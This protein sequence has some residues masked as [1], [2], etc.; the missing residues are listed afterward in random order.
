MNIKKLIKKSAAIATLLTVTTA[1][2]AAWTPDS[3]YIQEQYTDGKQYR[4]SLAAAEPLSWSVFSVQLFEFNTKGGYDVGYNYIFSYNFGEG[5]DVESDG[6]TNPSLMTR[7]DLDISAAAWLK[8]VDP[9]F[10]MSFLKNE[11]FE[12]GIIEFFSGTNIN[13]DE[14]INLGPI[15][16][17]LPFKHDVGNLADMVVFETGIYDDDYSKTTYFDLARVAKLS[18]VSGKIGVARGLNGG[19]GFGF[20]AIDYYNNSTLIGRQEHLAYGVDVSNLAG[21]DISI[22]RRDYVFSVEPTITA[23]VAIMADISMLGWNVAVYYPDPEE[24]DPALISGTASINVELPVSVSTTTP[25]VYSVPSQAEPE[26]ISQELYPVQVTLASSKGSVNFSSAGGDCSGIHCAININVGEDVTLT[27]QALSGYDHIWSGDCKQLNQRCVVSSTN[28]TSQ[29]VSLTYI[30]RVAPVITLPNDITVTAPAYNSSMSVSL[31]NASAIDDIDGSVAVLPSTTGPFGVGEH[32]ITWQ[33]IDSS[34]NRATAIQRVTVNSPANAAVFLRE[35]VLDGTKFDGGEQFQKTWTMVNV[36]ANTWNSS[37][38]LKH[39]TG[40]SIG[41]TTSTCVTGTVASG[42]SFTFSVTMTA[43]TSSSSDTSYRDYWR[44]N[45]NNQ[46]FGAGIWVDI[47][48]NGM[49]AP[50][51]QTQLALD[52]GNANTLSWSQPSGTSFYRLQRS[53]Y[54]SSGYNDIYSGANI[55]YTDE[56]L[57][58][59]TIYYYRILACADN[60]GVSCSEYSAPISLQTAM[61][62]SD[63]TLLIQSYTASSVSVEQGETTSLA[64]TIYNPG[65]ISSSNWF[66]A[67]FVLSTDNAFDDSD[68]LIY[69]SGSSGFTLANGNTESFSYQYTVSNSV[70]A[71]S[72]YLLACAIYK[73]SASKQGIYCQPKSFTVTDVAV[74][75]PGTPSKP[76][77]NYTQGEFS[78]SLEWNN[79]SGGDYYRLLRSTSSNGSYGEIYSGVDFSYIDTNVSDGNSYYYKLKSCQSSYITTCS[80]ESTY[81]SVSITSSVDNDFY[82]NSV[83][84][85]SKTGLN[86]D[87]QSSQRYTGNSTTLLSVQLGFYLSNDIDCSAEQDTFLAEVESG[88]NASDITDREHVTVTLPSGLTG[89]WFICSIADHNDTYQETD[90]SNNS[91]YVLVT[92][93]VPL[94]T[95][96]FPRWGGQSDY[97]VDLSWP[98]VSGAGHY[99]VERSS[100]PDFSVVDWWDETSG[101]SIITGSTSVS[102]KEILACTEAYFRLNACSD[103]F[104]DNCST[105]PVV[106]VTTPADNA[107]DPI[108]TDIGMNFVALSWEGSTCGSSDFVLTRYDS[109]YGDTILYVGSDTSFTDKYNLSPNKTYTYKLRHLESITGY[110]NNRESDRSSGLVVTTLTSEENNEWEPVSEADE[111]N[112]YTQYATV[113]FKNKIWMIGGKNNGVRVNSIWSSDDN[114]NWQLE[115]GNAPFTA[116][117]SISA[118]VHNDKVYVF[119]G[120]D[121]IDGYKGDIWTSDDGKTWLKVLENAPYPLRL[122]AAITS[123]NNKLWVIGGDDLVDNSELSDVWSSPDG[124]NW[125]QHTSNAPFG[126][127]MNT[128]VYQTKDKLFIAGGYTTDSSAYGGRFPRADI[129]SS[130]DGITWNKELDEAPWGYRFGHEVVS[131]NKYFWLFGGDHIQPEFVE[132]SAEQIFD[133]IYKYADDKNDVWRSEDGINWVEYDTGS[134][135]PEN[136]DV[137]VFDNHILVNNPAD[138]VFWK[139]ALGHSPDVIQ[140]KISIAG[141]SLNGSQLTIDTS[142]LAGFAENTFTYQWYLNGEKI[143]DS[144]NTSLHLT[145]Y[146]AGDQLGARLRLVD[147]NE[148][149]QTL[150]TEPVTIIS[151]NSNQDSD[152][153]SLPDVW[154]FEHGRDP[155]VADYQVSAGATHTCAKNDNEVTCWGDNS[156]GQTNVP[157]LLNP[158]Q[159][160]A[161]G[162]H[163]CALD[164]SGVKC[165]GRNDY[166]Q[167]AVPALLNV[168][169]ISTGSYHSCAIDDTGVVCWGRSNENQTTPPQLANP[170]MISAGGLHSC[171]IDDNGVQCWGSNSYSQA[172]PPML[173]NPKQIS[174]GG[175]H[176]CAIDDNGVQCWGKNTDNQTSVPSLTNPKYISAGFYH[177]CAIDDIGINCWGKNEPWLLNAPAISKPTTLSLGGL[178][179][180]ALGNE[181]IT[182]WGENSSNQSGIALSFDTDGDGMTNTFENEHGLNAYNASDAALDSD[183]DGLTNLEEYQAG[184][185]PHNN[186]TDGDGTVDGEDEDPLDAS[187]GGTAIKHD[188]NGDGKADI[189]WHNSQTGQSYVYLMNGKSVLQAESPSTREET[190]WQVVGR[191][192]FNGDGKADILWREQTTGANEI[193]LMSGVTISSTVS[194]GTVS[195]DWQVAGV[196]DINGDKVDDVLWQ[197]VNTGM[198]YG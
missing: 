130:Q 22:T 178:H 73:K 115:L 134:V 47:T 77:V 48:V 140:K 54:P 175:Y 173:A 159:I 93:D 166:N 32:E 72:Y 187:V 21:T 6:Y 99:F 12:F 36:G 60:S 170:T 51:F 62:T 126:K 53:E 121:D 63:E 155:F 90:E 28:T 110:Y 194:F 127:R 154:E 10:N 44:M 84:L 69:R 144:T 96:V 103:H 148:D 23:G 113:T 164:S 133:K 188:I 180:C 132:N 17:R 5:I 168:K 147:S 106:K 16:A 129:W 11:P 143:N 80:A 176:S 20:S 1:A 58:P 182:C 198:I 107:P 160:S 169:S 165:W 94:P 26:I 42:E 43:P 161:G 41:N 15:E 59:N 76:Y 181:G 81:S 89:S 149:M 71:G 67:A 116:R 46:F 124:S 157:A 177:S 98:S 193:D 145:N 52:G 135:L 85:L 192:D 39:N 191:G 104:L 97:K 29:N 83:S 78:V 25:K 125:I 123:F 34:G 120:Y 137:S 88:L 163:S 151:P 136:A 109:S 183:N 35:T 190:Q 66:E 14:E 8:V 24:A 56:G 112:N 86:L 38:C 61:P 75:V 167:S 70:T 92:T 114:E 172:T 64:A 49:L 152:N 108:A 9:G 118:V 117:S 65:Y 40:V 18:G 171:A 105:S 2:N 189:F 122:R 139:A 100:T 196:G 57:T 162:N 138:S 146:Q 33:A 79:S 102:N 31:G 150:W 179:S 13:I 50:T 27:A 82:V 153:D 7:A 4:Y 195:T 111:I 156:Y 68:T 30:N 87:L 19:I 186:D 95:V 158:K 141:F 119:G 128:A 3:N 184:T 45:V 91:A 185:D 74:D 55:S 142:L 174:L 101:T 197:N 131:F 37:Y